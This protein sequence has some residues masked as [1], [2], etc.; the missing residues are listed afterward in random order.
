MQKNRAF[1]GV[2]RACVAFRRFR[3][4]AAALL[5]TEATVF[6]KFGRPEHSC[7]DWHST[8]ETRNQALRGAVI[9]RFAGGRNYLGR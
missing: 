3:E 4:D 7:E 1:L 2:S 8:G 9:D 6:L 5:V